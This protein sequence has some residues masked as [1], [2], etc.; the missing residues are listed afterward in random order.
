[1][2]PG[3]MVV[4]ILLLTGVIVI[5]IL[6]IQSSVR[7]KK[8]ARLR[9]WAEQ[10]GWRYDEQRPELAHQFDG[11]PFTGGRGAKAEHVLTGSHRGHRAVL[12]EYTYTSSNGQT[13]TQHTH[14]IT[15][16]SLPTSTPVLE[17]KE[18]HL[19]HMLL[20]LIGFH[21]VQ[22][23]DEEFDAT[24]RVSTTD[25]DFA[26]MVLNADTRSWLL[27]QGP[28]RRAPF[29]FTGNHLISWESTALNPDYAHDVADYLADLVDHVPEHAWGPTT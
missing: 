23:G 29:R 8:V 26:H 21:D 15:A 4:L 24:F 17:V 10:Q 9:A 2:E 27:A 3:G 19:G 1:M 22:L 28:G 14:Q 16:L 18:Q 5:V 25:D 7:Q 11:A 6:A 20:N 12:Y 13:S